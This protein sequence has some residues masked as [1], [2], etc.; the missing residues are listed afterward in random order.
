MGTDNTE[1]E[2]EKHEERKEDVFHI[3]FIEGGGDAVEVTV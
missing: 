3:R 2:D 1:I